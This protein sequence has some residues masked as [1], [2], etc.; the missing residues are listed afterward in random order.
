MTYIILPLVIT[1][2]IEPLFFFAV[3]YRDK[4]F[5]IICL[6]INFITNLTMTLF[7]G[8]SYWMLL[9]YHWENTLFFEI[10]IVLVEGLVYYINDRRVIGFA[11]SL[12]A[13]ALS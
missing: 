7:M 3:G 13:N 6:L 4:R 2:I 8:L 1:L 5:F 12:A 10:G 9:D 11:W